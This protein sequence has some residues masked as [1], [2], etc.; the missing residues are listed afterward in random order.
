MIKR[1]ANRKLYDMRESCYITHDEIAS[2]VKSGEDVQII[3]NKTKE[4]LT[5]LTLTQ[6]LFRE[7]KMQRKTLPLQTLR[8]IL[9]SGGDFIQRQIADPLQSLRDEAGETVRTISHVFRKEM[10]AEGDFQSAVV[11]GDDSDAA[12]APEPA[13]IEPDGRNPSMTMREWVDTTQR[14]FETFQRTFEERW[15]LTFNAL[16]LLNES[17]RRIID[18]EARVTALE[19]QLAS[20]EQEEEA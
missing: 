11:A 18:L 7:E 19:S 20:T 16:T 3:D 15:N 6:I 12:E 17:R 8:G 1:Y 13:H 2:L 14:S 4:D 5:T 10:E 9:Q